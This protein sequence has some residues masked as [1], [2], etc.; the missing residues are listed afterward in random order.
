MHS[1]RRRVAY[2]PEV[3]RDEDEHDA[4]VRGEPPPEMVAEEQKIN[5]DDDG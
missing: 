5:R 2:E 1:P 3:E 4:D